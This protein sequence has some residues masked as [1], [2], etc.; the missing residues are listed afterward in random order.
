MFL[1]CK[2]GDRVLFSEAVVRLMKIADSA[3]CE[4]ETESAKP[5]SKAE[6]EA[7]TEDEART[8]ALHILKS[9][10]LDAGLAQDVARYNTFTLTRA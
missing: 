6:T 9:L 5:E 3:D 8:H 4:V 1:R 10:A 7:E 2:G